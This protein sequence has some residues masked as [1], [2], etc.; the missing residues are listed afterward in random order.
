MN[1]LKIEKVFSNILPAK[2]NSAIFEKINFSQINEIRLRAGKP[3]VVL[4]GGLSYF[5]S[6]Q[7]ICS[8]LEKAIICSKEEIE[9]IVF[10]ASDCS[11]YA[12]NDQ[13]K[14]GFLTVEGGVRIGIAGNIVCENEKILTIKS[15]S[16]LVIRIPHAV[17]NCSLKVY[18]QV[19]CENRFY[20]TLIISPPGAGK[21]TLLR[22]FVYQ[23]SKNNICL[24][25][26]VVD[27]RGEL[28]GTAGGCGL[29]E[30][31]FC[32]VLSNVSKSEGFLIGVRSLSPSIV[33]CD[34]I[35]SKNDIIALEYVCNCGVGVVA[36]AH[37][38]SIEELKI[39]QNFEI[40]FKNKLFERYVVLS[41][42]EGP[43]TV[44][45]IYDKNFTPMFVGGGL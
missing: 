21:T 41:G 44:E 11:I 39:K 27:E 2:L 12:V 15:F 36:T 10:R 45:G 16:S 32:D 30:S 31:N 29:L 28:S 7:G 38:S 24:N 42:R 20:N 14:N 18:N 23:L 4:L 25:V 43:G 13:I 3:V 26:L 8:N 19:V 35:G 17:K 34:E 40:L 5:L 6:E 37:A 1:K 9:N 22:D 33:V